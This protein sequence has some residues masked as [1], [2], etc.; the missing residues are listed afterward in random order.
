MAGPG[1]GGTP[2][3]AAGTPRRSRHD[4]G[5]AVLPRTARGQG[6]HHVE[7]AAQ[8][9]GVGRTAAYDAARRGELPTRRLGRR[10]LVPVPAHLSFLGAV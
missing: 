7:Q 6:N 2:R 1:G 9:L 4:A 5:Y 10:L 3:G 8:V